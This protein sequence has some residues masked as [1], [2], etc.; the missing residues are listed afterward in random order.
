MDILA[1]TE[2]IQ[3]TIDLGESQFR[4][5]KS[6]Y[7]GEP[8]NKIIREISTVAKDI[9]ETLVAF[10]NADGGELLVGVEDNREITGIAFNEKQISKLF[11]APINLVHAETPL[12]TPVALK[13]DIA[14]KTLLYFAVDKST[15][16]IHQTSDGRCLQRRDLESSPVSAGR[17]QFERQEQISREYD[18]IFVDGAEVSDLD[19]EILK[20]VSKETGGMSP[21]KSLQYLGLAEYG[22]N[23]LML[24]RAAVLLFSKSVAHWHPRCQV[25]VMRI[26]GTEL[27]TG[28]NY[29]VI[30][31]ETVTGN[32]IYLLKSAWEQLRPHLVQ[33][34]LT[35]EALFRESIMYP[36]DAVR[37]ALINAITH[38]DY[39]VEGKNIEI[40]IFDDRMTVSSPGALLSTIKIE[41]LRRQQG[42][43][44]SRNSHIAR[45]LREVGYVREMGEGMR[46]IFKLM[47]DADLVAPEVKSEHGQFAVTLFHKSVFSPADQAWLSGYRP[48]KLSREEMLVAM[49][50]RDGHLL[51]PQKLYNVLGLHDWDTYRSVYEQLSCKEVIYNTLSEVEKNKQRRQGISNRDVARLSIRQPDILEKS[52][53]E[54]YN[55]VSK[56]EPV[57]HVG[58]K[59]L[60]MVKATLP[61][62]NVYADQNFS[63]MSKL[64]KIL[65]LVDENNYP[66]SE[67]KELWLTHFGKKNSE[68]LQHHV[69]SK[70]PQNQQKIENEVK[71]SRL[72]FRNLPREITKEILYGEVSD[73]KDI[74]ILKI[75]RGTAIIDFKNYTQAEKAILKLNN[76]N[77]LGRIIRISQFKEY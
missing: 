32:I 14:G 24:R 42:A 72:V 7:Q 37:E 29:N 51:S 55:S 44:E 13:V 31:D 9:A 66:T 65:N 3:R 48:L 16:F 15:K 27:Q 61:K 5:F 36:E 8:G 6:G 50:G 21:E 25:R 45:V 52:I 49:L 69:T 34:K 76:K 57:E 71:E 64:F 59:F 63:R 60:E 33:T 38:R 22:R 18:R 62:E 17:L 35:N 47:K 46:R 41:D 26:R 4:E 11:Q 54:L 1:L 39:S 77:I 28:R 12:P 23:T 20:A 30:S 68:I 74:E 2:R 75:I 70:K 10:A 56:L 43:H 53:G 67:L 73:F 40:N 58:K 19:L